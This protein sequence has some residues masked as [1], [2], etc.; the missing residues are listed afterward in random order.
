M[1]KVVS[2][3]DFYKKINSAKREVRQ[4]RIIR[5]TYYQELDEGLA[6]DLWGIAKD[7]AGPIMNSAKTLGG[8]LKGMFKGLLELLL[9]H[10]LA[11]RVA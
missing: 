3:I 9:D 10:L 11:L 5:E 8:A 4:S 2:D 6:E 1:R 7:L